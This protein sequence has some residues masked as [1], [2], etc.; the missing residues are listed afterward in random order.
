MNL[1]AK[2]AIGTLA[3][4]LI[5]AAAVV[6]MFNVLQCEA[7]TKQPGETS[8][9]PPKPSASASTSMFQIAEASAQT[10]S[11]QSAALPGGASS[12]QENYQDW[13][14]LC[15]QQAGAEGQPPIKRCAMNQQQV[16]QQSGQRVLSLELRQVGSG[17]EGALYLPFGLSLDKGVTLQIDGGQI[18]QPNR[19]RTC[20]PAG[21]LVP[22]TFDAAYMTALE[23]ASALK[24]KAIAD[25]GAETP[26]SI[27][28]KGFGAASARLGAL[29]K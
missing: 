22:L 6:F 24:I 13:V 23:K 19:F 20:L 15:T 12:L 1:M 4:A 17:F 25:G 11:R 18:S 14:V 8:Q 5:G 7:N 21:C 9:T 26:F 27:S 3:T 28:M 29:A 2:I 16:S 10:G